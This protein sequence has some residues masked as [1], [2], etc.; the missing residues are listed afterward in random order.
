MSVA[1]IQKPVVVSPPAQPASPTQH[2]KGNAV[3]RAVKTI[4]NRIVDWFKVDLQYRGGCALLAAGMTALLGSIFLAPVSISLAI[5]VASVG[6]ISS[7]AGSSL[8]SLSANADAMRL[9]AMMSG[10]YIPV[11]SENGGVC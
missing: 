7:V 6:L 8:M 4:F 3:V 11:P 9:L 2:D 1:P 5:S 10:R